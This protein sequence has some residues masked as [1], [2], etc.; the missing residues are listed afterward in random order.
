MKDGNIDNKNWRAGLSKMLSARV[1]NKKSHR[2]QYLI[3]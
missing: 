3:T 1:F 2:F